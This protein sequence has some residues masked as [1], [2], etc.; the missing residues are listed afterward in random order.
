GR[1]RNW[2]LIT[3]CPAESASDRL[4]ASPALGTLHRSEPVGLHSSIAPEPPRGL[5]QMLITFP[6]ASNATSPVSGSDW[7]GLGGDCSICWNAIELSGRTRAMT[8][9]VGLLV[10]ELVCPATAPAPSTANDALVVANAGG[11]ASGAPTG[12]P[13][14]V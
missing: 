5:P 10:N 9:V 3:R 13:L 1:C 12:I 6:A 7:F 4:T 14:T 2:P 8:S 11:S